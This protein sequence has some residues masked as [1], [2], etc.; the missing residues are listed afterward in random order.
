ML[1]FS[2]A[3]PPELDSDSRSV[4]DRVMKMSLLA[5]VLLTSAALVPGPSEAASRPN[6]LLILADDLGYGDVGCYNRESR[7]PTPRVDRLAR[8]GLRFTDAHSPSTV[9]T[10][11]RY[12]ILTG[13]MAFRLNY[14]SVFTG[15][16]GPC[17]IEKNRL[18]LPAMLRE[19]GYETALFGKWH[20]GLTFSDGEGE[21]INED[22]L[23]AVQRID[24]TRAIEGGP[25]DQGFDHFFGTASC[26]TTDWLYAYID[27]DRVPVPPTRQIDKSTLPDHEW[28]FDCR[29]GM[30][31]EDFDLEEV[32]QVFLE[33]SLEFLDHHAKTRP[34]KPFFLFHSLQAVH[35]PSFPGEAFRGKTSAGPHGDFIFQFDQ[36]VGRL[37]DKLDELGIAEDTLVVVTSDNGPEVG[38]VL[39]MRELHDHDG[40]RPWR[41]LKRDNWEGGHRVPMVARWPGKIAAGTET[42]QTVCLTDLMATCAAI[43]GYELPHDAAEDSFDLLPVLLGTAEAPVRDHTIHQTWTLDLAIRKGPWKYLDHTGSG[44]NRYAQNERLKKLLPPETAPDAPGQLY[45]LEDDPR[46]LNNL[47]FERPERVKELKARLEAAKSSGRSAPPR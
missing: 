12:S 36:T 13:H 28:S 22:G 41:G 47:Y 21:P 32:D 15:A 9:C 33:K 44:G 5:S 6:V 23:E 46:E 25:I 39:R 20:V 42:D 7:I 16:G 40:A 38:T 26:P 27:G 34:D 45:H 3:G 8:E 37:M 30:V 43:V 4:A 24:Y 18:T 31:A 19:K 29:P 14:R 11:S 1:H 35:L 2:E 10:P 17:L